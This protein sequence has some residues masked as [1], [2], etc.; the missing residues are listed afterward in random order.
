MSKDIFPFSILPF[1]ILP[2]PLR[3]YRQLDFNLKKA[4][5][6]IFFPMKMQI[7]VKPSVRNWIVI[8]EIL[9]ERMNE[10]TASEREESIA[11]TENSDIT[12]G[13]CLRLFWESPGTCFQKCVGGEASHSTGGIWAFRVRS[14][15]IYSQGYHFD[16]FFKIIRL[17]SLAQLI[18]RV[19]PL[20][21]VQLPELAA[22]REENAK[23]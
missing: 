21:Q 16:V 22:H 3:A 7:Q 11:Q 18:T 4:S 14:L 1:S 10:W 19:V 15:L 13:S 8:K 9:I 12:R 5:T 2:A 20:M 6:A 23:H 17:A